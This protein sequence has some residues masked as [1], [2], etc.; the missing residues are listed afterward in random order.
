MYSN[1]VAF[2]QSSVRIKDYWSRLEQL[3]CLRRFSSV[4]GQLPSL[5]PSNPQDLR[6][7][8][9]NPGENLY[10]TKALQI[11]SLRSYSTDKQ[12]PSQPRPPTASD[13]EHAYSVLSDTLPKLFIQPLDYSIY[14]PNL[15]FQNN[16]TGKHTIGLY[17]Y[18]KQIALLRTVGHLKYAYV[19]LEVLKITKHPEDFTIKI[20]WRVRGI[21]GL[22]V[23]LNFWKYKLWDLKGVFDSQESWYDGFSVCYLGDNGLIY[24]HVV[25]KVMPDQNQEVVESSTIVEPGTMAVSSKIG[26]SSTANSTASGTK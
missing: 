8:L 25:D 21:S 6:P 18:V 17:H 2:R 1:T 9:S 15:E 14:S 11:K 5:P 10:T 13:L 26:C 20:R 23:M 19:K 4:V 7:V 24:K 22:K 12:N 16:I 3:I